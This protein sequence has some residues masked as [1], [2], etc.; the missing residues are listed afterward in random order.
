MEIELHVHLFKDVIISIYSYNFLDNVPAVCDV[1]FMGNTFLRKIFQTF[2]SMKSQA[3]V[4]NKLK[5]FLFEYYNVYAEYPSTSNPMKS[6]IARF[7]NTFIHA[8]NDHARLPK[9]IIFA[10][11]K[12]IVQF[13]KQ[14]D[15]GAVEM[16]EDLLDWM[17]KNFE[18]YLETR[19]EDICGKHHGALWSY[20]EPRMVWVKMIPRPFI[21]VELDKKFIFMQY[22]KFNTAMEDIVFKYCH[23][24]VMEIDFPQEAD[25]FDRSGHLSPNGKI[26]FW[27]DLDKQMWAFDRSEVDL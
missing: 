10:L 25:L 22:K 11:D 2:Q 9:Y 13:A 26:T 21:K 20:A 19:K 12:D 3:A 8:L 18:N 4:A 23:T 16:F 17:C 5:P 14:D 6:V 7:F 15:F 24:H 27:R 1:W